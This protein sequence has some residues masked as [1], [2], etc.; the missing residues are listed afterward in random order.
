MLWRNWRAEMKYALARTQFAEAVFAHLE[1]VRERNPQPKLP[2]GQDWECFLE[3][4]SMPSA[5]DAAEARR[6][7]L[8]LADDGLLGVKLRRDGERI[9]RFFVPVSYTHLRAHETGRNLVC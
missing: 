4:A 9:Q 3:E 1:R 7:A 6:A 2:W 8:A 5:E